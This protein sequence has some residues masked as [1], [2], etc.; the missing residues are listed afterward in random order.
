VRGCERTTAVPAGQSHLKKR[1]GFALKGTDLSVPKK[2]EGKERALAPK[3]VFEVGETVPQGLKP[4]SFA[5]FCGTDKSVPFKASVVL[6]S[7]SKCNCPS[8]SWFSTAG[9]QL[10]DFTV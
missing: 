8:S 4:A 10:Q 9:T 6:D 2:I 3:M 1:K 7:D 5:D